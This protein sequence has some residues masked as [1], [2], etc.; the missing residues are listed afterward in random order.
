MRA[1]IAIDPGRVGGTASLGP[2]GFT[3]HPFEGEAEWLELIRRFTVDYVAA[4]WQVEA[5]MEQVNGFTGQ[6]QPGSRMFTFGDGYGFMRGVLRTLQIPL[7]LYRPQQWQRGLGL[8]TRG[9]LTK[10]QWKR[11]L[12]VT[13]EQ[14][15]PK[16][17]VTLATADALL[18]LRYHLQVVGAAAEEVA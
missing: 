13:A 15:F 9:S 2:F 14:L 6:G 11:K 4:G 17:H 12:K 10:A 3:A 1:F 16:L 7:T 18:L 5:V 8:G